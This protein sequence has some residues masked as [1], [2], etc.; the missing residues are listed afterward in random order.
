MR[1]SSSKIT[2]A[3]AFNSHHRYR[4]KGKPTPVAPIPTELEA[5]AEAEAEADGL[6]PDY[7]PVPGVK[8]IAV[9][10]MAHVLNI[11]YGWE[12][13]DAQAKTPLRFLK[14][15]AEFNKPYTPKDVLGDLFEGT[16]AENIGG[17]IVQS[18]IPFRMICEHHLLPAVGH[19]CV[20]YIP[21]GKVVGLS[22]IARLVQA[23]GT[24]RPGMQEIFCEEITDVL[25]DYT[26]ANGTI[27][28]IKSLHTCMA[29]RGVYTPDT[30]TST[31]CVR[32][33]FRDVPSARSEFFAVAG[34]K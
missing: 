27:T 18:N 19:A 3:Q 16:K 14:Y 23:V 32:G 17:V 13:D 11:M 25:H 26:D 4:K 5:E 1:K 9:D 8:Q 24:S 34:I 12:S 6:N 22:K 30:L 29:C 20:G 7:E 2:P 10:A 21:R 31:S 33:L 28:V 15:L